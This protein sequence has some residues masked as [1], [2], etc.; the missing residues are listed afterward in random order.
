MSVIRGAQ[1]AG[2]LEGSIKT[3][4]VEITTKDDKGKDVIIPNPA[5][6]CWFAQDQTVLGYLLRNMTREVLIQV[7][8]LESS[9]KVWA[10]VTEMF[11]AVSQPHHSTTNCLG[12]NS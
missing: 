5:Y 9:A 12:Q 1:L 2:F 6:A 10:S 4:D 3:P 7:A 8:G 11:S